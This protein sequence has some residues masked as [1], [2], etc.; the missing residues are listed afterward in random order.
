MM[1]VDNAQV[2]GHL[3]MSESEVIANVDNIDIAIQLSLVR[4]GKT[5]I[6]TFGRYVQKTEGQPEPIEWKVLAK[7]DDRI[8][9][10]SRY[11]L[12]YKTYNSRDKSGIKWENC[13]L[14]KWLNETFLKAAFT[15]DEKA[16]ILSVTVNADKNP[17]FRISPGKSTTD[18]VF[19]LSIMEAEKYFET[20]ND[21]QCQATS[22]CQSKGRY[23]NEDGTCWWW[24]RSPGKGTYS[25]ADVR[26]NGNVCCEGNQ[27]TILETVR[28]ALWITLES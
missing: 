20:D 5:D 23:S 19:L 4:Q 8:L 3:Y 13:S 21:R 22:Y 12:E 11:A 15:K 6:V 16:L 25:A 1:V 2:G 18:R 27:I 28:P 9:L 26:G 14:R 10:I 7:E 24:L 17:K